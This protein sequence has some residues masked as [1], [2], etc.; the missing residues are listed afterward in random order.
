MRM[1]DQLKISLKYNSLVAVGKFIFHY[2][3]NCSANW[4]QK[5]T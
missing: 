4:K 1:N 5:I 2:T 3:I